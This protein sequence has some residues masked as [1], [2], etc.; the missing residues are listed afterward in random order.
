[1]NSRN[2][3]MKSVGFRRSGDPTFG[4][5]LFGKFLNLFVDFQLR[6]ILYLFKP[7]FGCFRISCW[8]FN[9]G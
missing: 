3:N 1:M 8:R 6:N 9:Q 2:S 5:Q 7:S 4:N